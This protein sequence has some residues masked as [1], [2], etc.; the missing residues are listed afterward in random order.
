MEDSDQGPSHAILL[1]Y[2]RSPFY[3]P[4]LELCF[5]NII[6]CHNCPQLLTHRMDACKHGKKLS[7]SR[8]LC[9]SHGNNS[10]HYQRPKYFTGLCGFCLLTQLLT[11]KQHRSL[12]MWWWDIQKERG[13]F[14]KNGENTEGLIIRQWLECLWIVQG[15]AENSTAN[16]KN[17]DCSSLQG[18]LIPRN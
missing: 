14:G 16:D 2:E 15:R 8:G 9:C 5:L 17:Q 18:Q 11:G 13:R 7:F 12:R 10:K 1:P 3:T 4:G 6:F